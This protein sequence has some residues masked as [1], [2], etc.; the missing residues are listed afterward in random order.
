MLN[1]L[2]TVEKSAN[3]HIPKS[4]DSKTA[5]PKSNIPNW[6]TEIEPFKDSAH[7]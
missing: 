5:K 6:K 2:L 3:T 1:V 7:F 4:K